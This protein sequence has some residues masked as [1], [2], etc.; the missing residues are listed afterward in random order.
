M[1]T[2]H[3]YTACEFGNNKYYYYPHLRGRRVQYCVCLLTP[4]FCLNSFILKS[5]EAASLKLGN[6]R[7]KVVLYKAGKFFQTSVAQ[8]ACKF[9]NKKN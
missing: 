8:I 4:N 7:Q 2:Q 9:E 5:K 1:K 3:A 6:L